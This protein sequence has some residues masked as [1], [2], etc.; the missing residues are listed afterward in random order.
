MDLSVAKSY[1]D[2]KSLQE[3][4]FN[5]FKLNGRWTYPCLEEGMSRNYSASEY[6]L[7]Q[8]HQFLI[9]SDLREAVKKLNASLYHNHKNTMIHS[10]S[11]FYELIVTH[12][13]S[14]YNIGI[15]QNEMPLNYYFYQYVFS[16]SLKVGSNLIIEKKIEVK[17]NDGS[18]KYI[19]YDL[20]DLNY[21][22]L[23][24]G[25]AFRLVKEKK[26][27]A[28]GLQTK[29]SEQYPDFAIYINGLP[30]YAI[31]VKTPTESW[32]KAYSDY[33]EKPTYHVF[34]SCIG[35]DGIHS[36]ISATHH[37]Y[38]EPRRWAKYGSRKT[39]SSYG[40]KDI[41]DEL[42][43]SPRRLMY[44]AAV[45]LQATSESYAGGRSDNYLE[46]L[47]VQQYYT[48]LE[49]SSR[50]EAMMIEKKSGA[51]DFDI[52]KEVVKHVQRSGKSKTIRAMVSALF[53]F[54]NTLF[55]KVY[56]QVPDTTIRNQ[57]LNKTFGNHF[58]T[59]VGTVKEIKNQTQYIKSIESAEKGVYIMNMQKI[60]EMANAKVNKDKDV[61]I[62]LDEV[63]T[64]QL[65]E[66]YL[67]RMDNFPNAS[68]VSFTATPR[69]VNKQG[70]LV[71][72]TNTIYAAGKNTYM[73]EFTSADAIEN[74][75]IIPIIYQ[76]ANYVVN[77]NDDALKDLEE[78]LYTL[79]KEK[80]DNPPNSIW[81]YYSEKINERI[82]NILSVATGNDFEMAKEEQIKDFISHNKSDLLK[83]LYRE[84]KNEGIAKKLD[85]IVSDI[86]NKREHVYS[87]PITG[88]AYFKTKSFLVV[89]DI[90]MATEIICHIT[91]NN[92]S[93]NID[94][95]RFAVD[96]SFVSTSDD[97]TVGVHKKYFPELY[98]Y[99]NENGEIKSTGYSLKS[100]DELNGVPEGS[101]PI[102][103]DFNQSGEGSVDV[104]IIVGK[105]IMGYDNAN[106]VAVYCD[107]EFDEISRIYQLAT[108]PATKRENK[109]CGYFVD[110]GIGNKNA[111]AYKNAVYAYES[112]SDKIAS[113]VLDDDTLMKL[114][115]E[116]DE[117]LENMGCLLNITY[118]SGFTLASIE[119][120]L[121]GLIDGVS[122][123]RFFIGLTE[124]NKIIKKLAIPMNY[125]K[126]KQIVSYIGVAVSNYFDLLKAKKDGVLKFTKEDIRSEINELFLSL[127]YPGGIKDVLE[128]QIRKSNELDISDADLERIK[129][130][131]DIVSLKTRAESEYKYVNATIYEKIKDLIKYCD[132]STSTEDKKSVL[133]EVEA[134]IMDD[135]NKKHAL[136][137]A[138]SNPY[139]RVT[140][141]SF[142]A[143]LLA[144][145]MD[146]VWSK[147]VYSYFYKLIANDVQNYFKTNNANINSGELKQKIYSRYT[148][149]WAE[150]LTKYDA[151]FVQ[152]KNF[153]LFR[154]RIITLKNK[155]GSEN[156]DMV[157]FIDTLV[158][159]YIITFEEYKGQSYV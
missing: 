60:S 123:S 124:I 37:Q 97:S 112:S 96:Y 139:E 13:I 45:C 16:K 43:T 132:Q 40:A 27:R 58:I 78:H 55:R 57:F 126:Q 66:N 135:K 47:S 121:N 11:E 122:K 83:Q 110:L 6:T 79:V 65:G 85:W 146:D 26:I 24:T 140:H 41:V 99:T 52:L 33:V 144:M 145:E 105:Y 113:F 91:K 129:V 54:H 15:Q 81:A 75:I 34:W 143:L 71:N 21:S 20:V 131:K 151:G 51:Q 149:I 111:V 73:D 10:E 137:A 1:R 101:S 98:D 18:V 48:V 93:T 3:A 136:D 130:N 159:A 128:F 77:I 19:E 9:L 148:P 5:D 63:H 72:L 59:N 39:D 158:E 25:N 76:K 152:N 95:I 67:I 23:E 155:D 32:K 17:L 127:G 69:V 46:A 4:L 49:A 74:N 22:R 142:S 141:E 29:D 154:E 147:D 14:V 100:L 150:S 92:G 31:E 87:N 80:L 28:A 62:I 42:I 108:R 53:L 107:T 133:K 36:F 90:E 30:A 56:I 125:P 102:I 84:V 2:E 156:N 44:Y 115:N 104:L 138:F 94:G 50:F 38:R 35:I 64:H 70:R 103:S 89:D 86:K 61:L 68:Y 116:L 157:S 106:L 82:D 119:Q 118:P 109:K 153:P 88:D 12:V 117:V 114:N 7:L 8:E 120:A 134:I